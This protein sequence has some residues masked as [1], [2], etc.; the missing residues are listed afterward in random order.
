MCGLSCSTDK[1]ALFARQ[2]SRRHWYSLGGSRPVAPVVPVAA[3]FGTTMWERESRAYQQRVLGPIKLK[4]D[5]DELKFEDLGI[6]ASVTSLAWDPM[7]RCIS[8]CRR[9]KSSSPPI[10]TSHSTNGRPPSMLRQ[11]AF[12]YA[13]IQFSVPAV[14]CLKRLQGQVPHQRGLKLPCSLPN[15]DSALFP[16]REDLHNGP[17]RA[18]TRLLRQPPHV[19]SHWLISAPPAA[20]LIVHWYFAHGI[21]KF[22]AARVP[23]INLDLW[24]HVWLC[25]WV[26]CAPR[27][28]DLMTF[29]HVHDSGQQAPETVCAAQPPAAQVVRVNK[30]ARTNARL[31]RSGGQSGGWRTA[32]VT[33]TSVIFFHRHDHTLGI[34]RWPKMTLTKLFKGRAP[35]PRP[36][37]AEIEEQAERDA[38]NHAADAEEEDDPDD[39]AVEIPSEDEYVG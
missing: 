29:S 35:S 33:V 28:R 14:A 15:G 13:A 12:Q 17:R 39:G 4:F 2:K 19:H 26:I 5:G 23:V 21:F 32:S 8:G 18:H 3:G 16:P 24:V 38:Q 6:S 30:R 36:T 31:R 25:T 1:G 27:R 11:S 22:Y 9:L 37:R 10:S 20:N 7:T 34:K